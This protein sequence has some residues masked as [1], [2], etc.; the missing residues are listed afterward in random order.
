MTY[1][2]APP[3]KGGTL[4]DQVYKELLKRIR[5]GAWLP[6]TKLTLRSLSEELGTSVQPVRDAIGKL[7]AERA[8]VMRPNHSVALP[9][10]DRRLMAE[11]F[12]MANMLEGEAA[13]RSTLRLNELDLN[14]LEDAIAR[15]KEHYRNSG[16]I[17]ERLIALNDISW[18]LAEKSGSDLL[19]EQI[20]MLRTRTAP[21]YAA[22]MKKETQDDSDFIIFT[23]RIQ[24]EFLLAL[25]R[26]HPDEAEAIRRADIYT[27]QQY[28]FRRLVG[29]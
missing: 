21:Y 19:E 4:S 16:D 8:L 1:D 25:R 18:T 11:I 29:Q 6:G 14:Q 17:G 13:R 27:Y 5:R 26:R 3:Q 12:A 28:V 2:M 7:V 23:T 10:T 24:D 9:P 20:T 15:A 22:A